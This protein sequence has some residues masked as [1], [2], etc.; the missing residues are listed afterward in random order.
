VSALLQ[1]GQFF[2]LVRNVF[3]ASLAAVL[4]QAI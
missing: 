2:P 1:W 3:M 4:R